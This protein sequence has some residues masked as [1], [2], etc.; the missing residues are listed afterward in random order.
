[1]CEAHW[2]SAEYSGTRPDSSGEEIQPV[3]KPVA[4]S[5]G[6]VTQW[7]ED[8]A[9]GEVEGLPEWKPLGPF[10]ADLSADSGG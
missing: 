8:K 9:G 6:D 10:E 3:D 2:L 1:M 5:S 4:M 7:G